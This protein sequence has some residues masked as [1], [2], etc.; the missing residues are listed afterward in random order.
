MNKEN[1]FYTEANRKAWNEAMPYHQKKMEAEWTKRF[2][3]KGYICQKEPELKELSKIG[4]KDKDIA[5]LSCNNGVELMSLKNMGAGRCTGFD[6]SDNAIAE[7]KKRAQD[8]SIDCEFVRTDVLEISVE[9]YDS[10]DLVYITIGALTWIPDLSKYFDIAVKILRKGG[11]IFIYESHPFM[12][13][14]PW[15]ETESDHPL[16][17]VHPYFDEKVYQFNEGIDYVGGETYESS[18]TYEFMHTLSD[19]MMIII[20]LKCKINAFYEFPEDI[21]NCMG[22][23]VET[24]LKLPMSYILIAEK[25]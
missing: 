22:W 12:N 25:E 8:V 16:K 1:K 5:H 3:Q 19:L 13:V 7:A 23:Q 24:G 17:C 4:L 14:F 15:D 6:I 18:T 20:N 21:S 9:Y 2:Q 10:Y 11:K